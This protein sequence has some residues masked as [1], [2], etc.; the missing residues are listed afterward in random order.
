MKLT[1]IFENNGKIPGKYTCDG[2]NV[3]P[4]FFIKDIS[5]ETKSLVLIIDDPDAIKPAGKVWDHW[6]VINI[7]ANTSEIRGDSVPGKEL[8]NSS[9]NVSYHGPCPPDRE[10][11]YFFKLYALDIELKLD[12]NSN[13]KD[14]EREM[15]GHILAK[16]ELIGRYERS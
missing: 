2:D 13:K 11:R 12:S 16:A 14:V 15:Q 4:P 1:S 7:P 5:Q 8:I 6:V 9:N 10:H 3:N